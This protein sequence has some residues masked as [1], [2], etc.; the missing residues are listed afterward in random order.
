MEK[1]KFIIFILFFYC[2]HYFSRKL[3]LINIFYVII[4]LKKIIFIIIF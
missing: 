4:F 1:F 3:K 2:Y